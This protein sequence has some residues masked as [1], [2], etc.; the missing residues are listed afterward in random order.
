MQNCNILPSLPNTNEK[1]IRKA[2]TVVGWDQY[3]DIAVL[4]IDIE[5]IYKTIPKIN[6][7][8]RELKPGD[9]ALTLGYPSP[10]H[11][12]N[13]IKL[14]NGIINS[15]TGYQDDES[16]YQISTPIQPGNSGS[17]LLD[18]FG[19]IRGIIVASFT[20]GQNVNYAI[21]A[22][23][24][25]R[26]LKKAKINVPKSVSQENINSR[27]TQIQSTICLIENVSVKTHYEELVC[28]ETKLSK[29]EYYSG[30]DDE[31]LKSFFKDEKN[32]IFSDDNLLNKIFND[33]ISIAF[34]WNLYSH[35]IK[36]KNP[37]RYHALFNLGAY[38]NI[39][40][41]I[42]DDWIITDKNIDKLDIQALEMFFRFNFDIYI[43][44]YIELFG[45]YDIRKIR[46]LD[47]KITFFHK[48]LLSKPEYNYLA[49][50]TFWN[51]IKVMQ[52]LDSYTQKDIC[53]LIRDTK[54]LIIQKKIDTI[55]ENEFQKVTN[56]FCK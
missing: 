36:Y 31:Q 56:Y 5:G 13:K 19:N 34:F 15:T 53:D 33:K 6:F 38:E 30:C 39:I 43:D 4:K 3:N 24:I 1:K 18:K 55:D 40:Y 11:L 48:L 27:L 42:E 10:S 12:G 45:E 51:K 52:K 32:K 50:V 29:L 47:Q 14:S 2:A 46:E 35:F 44:S 17:P 25:N 8:S 23:E 7:T 54:E 22:E 20:R 21:K 37:T 41:D 49:D 9:A 26:V 16:C 28:G